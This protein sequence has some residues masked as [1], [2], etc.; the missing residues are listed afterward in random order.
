MVNFSDLLLTGTLENS[1]LANLFFLEIYG[2]IRADLAWKLYFFK[3][4]RIASEVTRVVWYYF[5]NLWR[6]YSIIFFNFSNNPSF[7][8]LRQFL[9]TTTSKLIF[10]RCIWFSHLNYIVDCGSRYL[11]NFNNSIFC[12]PLK[13]M[14]NYD[15]FVFSWCRV[16]FSVHLSQVPAENA[17]R[18]HQLIVLS[19]VFAI[20]RSLKANFFAKSQ[21][22]PTI[23]W[24][25]NTFL[26][27]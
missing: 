2:F 17:S 4:F 9:R 13:H 10:H 12:F 20:S 25:S 21:E 19:Y 1:S 27:S 7:I 24:L 14:L 23:V 5:C 11:H 3:L 6:N 18:K 15:I 16:A 26:V 22:F 8:S